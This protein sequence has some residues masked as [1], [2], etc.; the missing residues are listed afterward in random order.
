MFILHKVLEKIAKEIDFH[1]IK[2]YCERGVFFVMLNDQLTF[3]RTFGDHESETCNQTFSIE[4]L[5]DSQTQVARVCF[6]VPFL[7]ESKNEVH[8]G[9]HRTFTSLLQSSQSTPKQVYE[10]DEAFLQGVKQGVLFSLKMEQESGKNKT[11]F[12][13]TK[14]IHSSID[15]D[16]VLQMTFHT[17]H[18]LYAKYEAYIWLSQDYQGELPVKK[19]D[20][21]NG[22]SDINCQALIKGETLIY[23]HENK[24]GISSPLRGNQGTYGVLQL[25]DS[26][27]KDELEKESAHIS[28]LAEM[29]GTALENAKLYQHSKSLINQLQLVNEASEQ[30]SKTLNLEQNIDFMLSKVMGI[31]SPEAVHFLSYV[32]GKN[33]YRMVQTTTSHLQDKIFVIKNHQF[34]QE[35]HNS[36]ESYITTDAEKQDRGIFGCVC[37]LAYR[38]LMIVP[39]VHNKQMEGMIILTHSLPDQFSYDNLRLLETLVHHASFAF[40]N[41]SLHQEV[42]RMVITDN[43]TRL[44]ARNYLDQELSVSQSKDLSGSFILIDIDNFKGVNDTYGHQVGDDVLIQVSNVMKTCIRDTDIAARWGGEE[45]AIYLPNVSL[46]KAIDIAGRIRERVSRETSPTVTISCGI[47]CWEQ[48]DELKS[49]AVLFQKADQ[50][51]YKAKHAGKN[52]V[53]FYKESIS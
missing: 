52:Q 3:W 33:E 28:T 18:E 38:S 51:L 21:R 16:Q 44:Y 12:E 2:Q 41:S 39:M 23:Q 50:S 48:Q 5:N 1:S 24:V 29:V 32:K 53:V 17:V 13:M 4:R 7:D 47:S 45:L 22:E 8:L 31:F 9:V 34:L 26:A 49:M 35:I 11:L 19:L 14:Q 10:A 37:D 27:A 15:V 36:K 25:I 6:S 40:V 30:L 20:F 42:N 46:E 43:L